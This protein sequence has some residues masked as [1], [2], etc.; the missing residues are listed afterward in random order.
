MHRKNIQAL[1]KTS[2]AQI[3]NHRTMSVQI[4]FAREK[5]GDFQ[6]AA[7]QISN[8]YTSHP[9]L[10]RYIKKTMGPEVAQAIEPDLRQFGDRVANEIAELGWNCEKEQPQ[11]KHFDAWGK[12]VDDIKTCDSWKKLKDIA[13]EEGL[14]AHA[15]TKKHK[16]HS[17]LYQMIKLYLFSPSSGLFSC[18]L[19]MT[20]GAAKCLL[21]IGPDSAMK[22]PYEHLITT[23]P[24]DFWTS[25][26]WMTEKKGGS[27]VANGTET[28]AVLQDDGSYKLYGYKW[29]TSA[30]DSNMSLTLARIVS[31]D[32]TSIKGTK[33]LSMFYLETRDK[34]GNL[35]NIQ[36]QKLKDKLGTRQVPTAELLLDGTVAKLVSPIGQGIPSISDMLTLTRIHNT[37][38][39]AGVMRRTMTLVNDYSFKREAFGKLI[40]D[41]PL[42]TKV[43]ARMEVEARGAELLAFEVAKLLGRQEC[44]VS[45]EEEDQLL[46][47]LTPIAKLYT[48]K[49]AVAIAS[50]G[51][52]CFGG[53]GYIEDTGLPMILR[54]S[55][56]LPI[57]EGTT[58]IL[59]LD[60]LRCIVKSKGAVLSAFANEIDRKCDG[61]VSSQL[62]EERVRV[63]DSARNIIRFIGGNQDSLEVAARDLSYS[64]ARIYIASLLIDFSKNPYGRADDVLIAKK[65]CS[66][67][68][69]PVLTSHEKGDYK[70]TVCDGEY[71][72]IFK[73]K[74]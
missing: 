18:P 53:Q 37:L 68:L 64:L 17:R 33:G 51:L 55:Q 59:S 70:S 24:K 22:V 38:A 74:L 40:K 4:P 14:I 21:T 65:W 30:T 52:E 46:R 9:I 62:D 73:S 8:Q 42:H 44:K 12:R 31:N 56:V 69:T 57:W 48:A 3:L 6:Q 25:G 60:V 47:L 49:Q 20:D 45:N 39:A 5:R 11:L 29:F 15:Y 28:V 43:L 23:N 10:S 19:A 27:D 7:P 1:V 35:N 16:E 32:G 26:Q 58:N 36:V 13:A 66:Q 54:D 71:E 34:E 67:D 72:L 63:K 41:Y 2:R 50:E 61:E